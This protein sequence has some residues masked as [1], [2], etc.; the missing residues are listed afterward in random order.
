MLTRD[1]GSGASRNRPFLRFKLLDLLAVVC[2]VIV[3]TAA[4]FF[5]VRFPAGPPSP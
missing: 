2:F 3:V 4:S 5:L 1:S